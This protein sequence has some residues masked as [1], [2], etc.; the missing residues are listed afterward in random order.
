MVNTLTITQ[1]IQ[2][3]E[4]VSSIELSRNQK[5]L[6]KDVINN[7]EITNSLFLDIKPLLKD[8][9]NLAISEYSIGS[10][11]YHYSQL[12]L[13]STQVVCKA[14]AKDWIKA[15]CPQKQ[16]RYPYKFP[17]LPPWWPKDVPHV[18]PDHLSKENRIE[19]L[20]SIIRH[21]SVNLLQ[22][23]QSIN[24]NHLKN[25]LSVNMVYINKL[26]YEVFYVSLYER[27]ILNYGIFENS[28]LFNELNLHPNTKGKPTTLKI[29]CVD[30]VV[31]RTMDLSEL[32]HRCFNLNEQGDNSGKII[33]RHKSPETDSSDEDFVVK[34]RKKT[35]KRK[36][37][38]KSKVSRTDSPT[39]G[40][41][42][43]SDNEVKLE[44]KEA[45]KPPSFKP[46][47]A[48]IFVPDYQDKFIVLPV[49]VSS[50]P[51]LK[52]T[53][54][55]LLS[56]PKINPLEKYLVDTEPYC[57]RFSPIPSVD[58]FGNTSPLA[59][60]QEERYDSS[61]SLSLSDSPDT[62]I[63]DIK[64]KDEHETPFDSFDAFRESDS[65]FRFVQDYEDLL[66]S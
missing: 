36:K 49:P 66:S 40:F 62:S 26:I 63:S 20:I 47:T 61:P 31:L 60:L 13:L 16:A 32:N 39:L 35:S 9:Y 27:W 4:F 54:P 19:L 11:I 48:N 55:A 7:S 1:D 29:S 51:K 42:G 8:T 64:I 10:L 41:D 59:A 21:E 2:K 24:M 3:Y 45:V 46:P 58:N 14:L 17:E 52:S 44:F 33:L 18:E 22:L 38:K 53:Q 25:N 50:S 6:L 56:F 57:S 28:E 15:I 43:Y 37:W 12:F 5:K 34:K 23:R 30:S 65:N